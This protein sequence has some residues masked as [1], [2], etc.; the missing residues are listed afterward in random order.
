MITLP[1][2]H[3]APYLPHTGNMVLLDTITHYDNDNVTATAT[4]SANHILLPPQATALPIYLGVEILAQG[5][6]AWAGIQAVLRG[7]PVRLGFLLGSRKLQFFAQNIPIGSQLNINVHHSYQDDTGMGVF[8]CDL[9]TIQGQPLI[10]GKLTV[11]S[12]NSE[13][14]LHQILDSA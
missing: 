1:I 11:F 2:T 3:P 5:I 6:G 7:E 13:Q 8:D 9:S 12:P 4:I 10:T 14:A